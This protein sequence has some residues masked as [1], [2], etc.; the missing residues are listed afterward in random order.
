MAAKSS[1]FV[2]P[3]S[4]IS[5]YNRCD[6][7]NTMLDQPSWSQCRV[8]K[9]FDLCHQCEPNKG[10]KYND[11]PSKT[12]EK[13]NE[14][15]IKMSASKP[16]ND[17][18]MKIIT[19]DF[20]KP[21]LIEEVEQNEKEYSAG[22]RQK[23]LDRIMKNN[24]I[25]NDNDMSIVISILAAIGNPSSSMPETVDVPKLNSMVAQYYINA[26]KRNI[27]ILSLD[28]GGKMTDVLLSYIFVYALFLISRCTWLHAHHSS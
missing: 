17:D 7:C 18:F 28:G 13:H 14:L 21:I 1:N 27:H 19:D 9:F 10:R 2:R 22:L 12:R 11:L 25:E 15:H 20:M 6:N 26:F 8:C 16:E 5:T 23:L 24:K 4:V 3:I